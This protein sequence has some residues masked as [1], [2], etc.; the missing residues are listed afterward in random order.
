MPLKI[1]IA[2]PDMDWMN[3]AKKHFETQMYE[4]DEAQNGIAQAIVFTA[5]GNL[6]PGSGRS[7]SRK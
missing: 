4:V 3:N 5:R 1:L 6:S 2:D 7:D